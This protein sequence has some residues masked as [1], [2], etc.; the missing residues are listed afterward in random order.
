MRKKKIIFLSHSSN[1][2]GAEAS[3]FTLAKTLDPGKYEKLVICPGK[4]MLVEELAKAGIPHMVI[5]MTNW[6]SPVSHWSR[7]R[8][9]NVSRLS[10]VLIAREIKRVDRVVKEFDCEALVSNTVTINHGALISAENGIP[11]IWYIHELLSEGSLWFDKISHVRKIID[12]VVKNSDRLVFCSNIT[13]KAFIDNS[14]AKM[15]QVI[16]EKKH[17]LFPLS[18]PIPVPGP[19]EKSRG[20]EHRISVV[21]AISP[22]KGQMDVLEAFINIRKNIP[23]WVLEFAGPVINNRYYSELKKTIN[24]NDMKKQVKFRGFQPDIYTYLSG[25]DILV[26]PSWVETFGKTALDAMLSGVPVIISKNSGI[27][28]LLEDRINAVFI[29]IKSPVNISAAIMELVRDD[30]LR[31]TVRDNGYKR[32]VEI[33]N[34]DLQRIKFEEIL[35]KSGV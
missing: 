28:E 23:G 5:P 17:I 12:F 6:V 31:D 24:K 10:N 8:L 18:D 30:Q 29:D 14:D 20:N 22:Y 9:L 32:A 15:A 19:T 33:S 35:I 26:V 16:S 25:V 4:G 2:F 3:L 1:L 7:A 11:H 21:G 13:Y 34:I 27:C